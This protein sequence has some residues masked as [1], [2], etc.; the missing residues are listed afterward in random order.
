MK[1]LW[2]YNAGKFTRKYSDIAFSRPGDYDDIS[3]NAIYKRHNERVAKY[4]RGNA[5]T[6]TDRLYFDRGYDPYY[7]KSRLLVSSVSQCNYLTPSFFSQN[8]MTTFMHCLCIDHTHIGGSTSV[9]ILELEVLG[10]LY[11]ETTTTVLN[12]TLFQL[13]VIPNPYKQLNKNDINGQPKT[14]DDMYNEMNDYMDRTYG[15]YS[16]PIPQLQA[17]NGNPNNSVP[18]PENVVDKAANYTIDEKFYPRISAALKK[19]TFTFKASS[20]KGD[21]TVNPGDGIFLLLKTTATGFVDPILSLHTR[22]V[23]KYT[24]N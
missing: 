9:N 24:Q 2:R 5:V 19:V 16:Y 17:A 8:N 13:V 12:N 10:N 6:D 22:S 23:F 20:L 3:D 7:Y 18:F 15:V 11:L 21:I 14:T 1:S 4:Q